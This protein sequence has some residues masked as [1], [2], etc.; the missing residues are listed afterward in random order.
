LDVL[1]DNIA[2]D[3]IRHLFALFQLRLL[4]NIKLD[5]TQLTKMKENPLSNLETIKIKVS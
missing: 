1:A 2:F 5:N 3:I 4:E